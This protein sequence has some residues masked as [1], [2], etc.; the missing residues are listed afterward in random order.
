[1]PRVRRQHSQR[2]STLRCFVDRLRRARARRWMTLVQVACNR[3]QNGSG[4]DHHQTGQRDSSVGRSILTALDSVP[5][6][7]PRAIRQPASLP[8]V[9]QIGL[10]PRASQPEISLVSSRVTPQATGA[11]RDLS[12]RAPRG[13]MRCGWRAR[14]LTRSCWTRPPRHGWPRSSTAVEGRPVHHRDSDHSDRRRARRAPRRRVL[15]PTA[16]ERGWRRRRPADA[17]RPA[18]RHGTGIRRA[19]RWR[20]PR[21]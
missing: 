14:R 15:T 9:R 17:D 6:E 2:R 10:A 20:D 19:A 4:E 16:S 5:R 13:G 11:R 7:L 12:H 18:W 8:L 3:Q 1:M 21:A